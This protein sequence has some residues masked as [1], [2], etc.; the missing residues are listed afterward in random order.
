MG[1]RGMDYGVDP[2]SVEVFDAL[3]LFTPY[4]IDQ[5]KIRVGAARD[6]GYIMA[7]IP[8]TSE[9]FSF[10]IA[11]D[12]RF[13]KSMA[14]AG[15]RC[16]MYDHTIEDLPDHHVNFTFHRKGI[17]GAN[18]AAPDLLPLGEHLKGT[19]TSR[20]MVLKID[21]EGAEW[22]AFA[23]MPDDV[24]ARF[25][26]IVGEFHWLHELGKPDFRSVVTEAM[27]R[28]SDCFTLFHVHANNCR[29]LAV[30][31]GFM[32]A[33]V[34][35]LSF[36]RTD[37]VARKRSTTL[38]P[39]IDDLGNNHVVHDHALLFYP[40]LPTTADPREI[41]DMIARIDRQRVPTK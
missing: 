17:C 3:A 31:D 39:T 20:S 34:L 37:L 22:D 35:E 41:R 12:V 28:I 24:L 40:F 1:N 23:T 19:T 18:T 30:V 26:Q 27:R 38:Y 25:D 5:T 29:K 8:S 13:E 4:D 33:D 21:V 9:L 16:F 11:N 10:G 14:E 32:V 2:M 7:D 6:G 15:H 36:V